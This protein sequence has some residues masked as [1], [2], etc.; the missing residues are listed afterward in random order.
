MPEPMSPPP[1]MPTCSTSRP[2]TDGSEVPLS[3]LSAVVAKKI[4]MSSLATGETASSPK[5]R[6]SAARP[7]S[8]PFSIPAW[9]ASRAATGAG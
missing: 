3:F 4:P 8:I 1:R 2:F 5:S 6:A 7:V 9:T